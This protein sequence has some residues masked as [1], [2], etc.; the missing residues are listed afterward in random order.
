M[1]QLI[2]ASFGPNGLTS[3]EI[4]LFSHWHTRS[5]QDRPK[6]EPFGGLRTQKQ[7]RGLG[8]QPPGRADI[9]AITTLRYSGGKRAD[10]GQLKREEMLAHPRGHLAK[11]KAGTTGSV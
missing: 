2:T 6:Q 1:A 9:M 5:A 8:V 7:G 4:F 11:Q 10:G 3:R